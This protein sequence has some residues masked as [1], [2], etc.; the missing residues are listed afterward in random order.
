MVGCTSLGVSTF[1][2][3]IDYSILMVLILVHKWHKAL[4]CS[5]LDF[6]VS[7]LAGL[8]LTKGYLDDDCFTDK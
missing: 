8:P 1:W 4:V 2:G 7:E 5:I 3:V 6:G